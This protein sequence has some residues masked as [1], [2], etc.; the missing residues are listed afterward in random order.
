MQVFKR[1]N[2]QINKDLLC[3]NQPKNNRYVW[4]KPKQ[5]ESFNHITH[6]S[7]EVEE[8]VILQ[9]EI[10]GDCIFCDCKFYGCYAGHMEEHYHRR[11]HSN[12]LKIYNYVLLRCKCKDVPYRG[13]DNYKWNSHWHCTECYKPVN[14]RKLFVQHLRQRHNYHSTI[15]DKLC[16]QVYPHW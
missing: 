9:Q 4:D 13:L 16:S 11:H 10:P 6:L 5:G 3:I 12:A 14:D 8:K 2:I 1:K 15:I 7:I